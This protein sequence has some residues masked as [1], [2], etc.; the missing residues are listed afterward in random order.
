MSPRRRRF[1]ASSTTIQRTGWLLP[2][3]AALL[4]IS[5]MVQ[6]SSR[7][8]GR[9]LSRRRMARVVRIA[10]KRSTAGT[11]RGGEGAVQLP[12]GAQAA[13]VL[14]DPAVGHPP[15]LDVVDGDDAT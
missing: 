12:A 9:S 1:A 5:R 6:M 11:L 2:P 14:D 15:H 8:T 4:A 10:S 3:V 13:P 7:D